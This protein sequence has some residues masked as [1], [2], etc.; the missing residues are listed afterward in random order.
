MW[1]L[2]DRQ[3]CCEVLIQETLR[4][5][6][7]QSQKKSCS[8]L[9]LGVLNIIVYLWGCVLQLTIGLRGKALTV[10]F[11]S[12]LYFSPPGL[13]GDVYLVEAFSN[14]VEEVESVCLRHSLLLSLPL[15]PF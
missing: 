3:G 2:D 7:A 12:L 8:A 4:P 1:V 13:G 10:P 15:S 5:R 11:L 6:R 14:V 9:L